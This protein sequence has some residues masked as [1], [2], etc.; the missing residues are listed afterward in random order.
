MRTTD[1]QVQVFRHVTSE[2]MVREMHAPMSCVSPAK[3]GSCCSL[4]AN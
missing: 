4:D 3:D 1:E 2:E